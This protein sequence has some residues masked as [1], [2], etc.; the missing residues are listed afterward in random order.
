MDDPVVVR[1]RERSTDL[2]HDVDRAIRR[3]TA[4]FVEEALQRPSREELHHDV[5]E[6]V[7]LLTEVEDAHDVRVIELARGERLAAEA[8]HEV[9]VLLV[10]R[11]EDFDGDG[12]PELAMRRLVHRTRS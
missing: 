1:D 2:D 6:A 5:D 9:R 4:L 12:S 10:V 8:L 11:M 7:A 3:E